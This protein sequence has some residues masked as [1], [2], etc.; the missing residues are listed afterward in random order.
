MIS[1]DTSSDPSPNLAVIVT[2]PEIRTWTCASFRARS[3]IRNCSH[4]MRGLQIDRVWLANWYCLRSAMARLPP[5]TQPFWRMYV[6]IAPL[7]TRDNWRGSPPNWSR[8]IEF[9][10]LAADRFPQRR[11][12]RAVP[13]G[14]QLWRAHAVGAG[15]TGSYSLGDALDPRFGGGFLC[16]S[17]A[18]RRSRAVRSLLSG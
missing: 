2:L 12:G 9:S 11:H 10:R 17:V 1:A 7:V 4:S 18:W 5:Q 8:R 3:S 6:A 16:T 14:S 13:L 15:N